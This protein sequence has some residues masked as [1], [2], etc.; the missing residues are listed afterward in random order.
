MKDWNAIKRSITKRV[1]SDL[2]EQPRKE[3]RIV[4]KNKPKKQR[5]NVRLHEELS[6]YE[7]TYSKL[8]M[9][10]KGLETWALPKRKRRK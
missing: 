3:P 9:D 1:N 2:A 5:G 8:V 6:M 4:P 10:Y 7:R